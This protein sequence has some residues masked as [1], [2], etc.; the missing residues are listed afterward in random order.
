MSLLYI[1]RRFCQKTALS[2]DNDADRL[3]C[4]DY[5]NEAARELYD[6]ADYPYCLDEIVIETN[7]TGLIAL[8]PFVGIPRAL[9]EV[10]TQIPWRLST[11][12]PRY[13]SSGWEQESYNN[14]RDV[15]YSPI[16]VELTNNAP[17]VVVIPKVDCEPISVTIVGSTA[18][19][20]QV[21]ETRL[22][23]ELRTQFE[24]PFNNYAIIKK[25]KVSAY[26]V[27]IEDANGE[28]ISIIYNNELE[29]SFRIIDASN[30]PFHQDIDQTITMELLYKKRLPLLVNDNDEFILKDYDDIVINKAVQLRL[31]DAGN[32]DGAVAY[33]RKAQRT[34]NRKALNEFK[35]KDIRVETIAHK[36]DVVFSRQRRRAYFNTN[37]PH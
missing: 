6:A 14:W 12:R 26:D 1:L 35:G 25:D 37:Y 33:D 7:R 28:E 31:E 17:P 15:G 24:T 30:Y 34:A 18:N 3:V 2:K 21:V 10:N 16:A 23:T 9:R 5:I 19:A 22:I 8:P 29:A 13:H 4:L 32:T 27:I 20:N 36:H 11:M